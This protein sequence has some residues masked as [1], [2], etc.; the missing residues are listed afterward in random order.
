MGKSR[1]QFSSVNVNYGP[2]IELAGSTGIALKDAPGLV[3]TP[4]RDRLFQGFFER[5]EFNRS[6]I[7]IA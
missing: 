2:Q 6:R 3:A 5:S 1:C 7:V 4:G